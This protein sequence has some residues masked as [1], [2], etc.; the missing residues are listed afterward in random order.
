MIRDIADYYVAIG[1]HILDSSPS[2]RS[3]VRR[4]LYWAREL[5]GRYRDVENVSLRKEFEEIDAVLEK[6]QTM[7]NITA[8]SPKNKFKAG[9]SRCAIS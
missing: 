6:Q 4:R 9:D 1:K 7:E 3:A 8:S 5:Y 2:H